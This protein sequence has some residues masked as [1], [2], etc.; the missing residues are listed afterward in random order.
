[1]KL[2]VGL[3]NPGATPLGGGDMTP[4]PGVRPLKRFGSGRRR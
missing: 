4:T 1:M 3:G 2:F